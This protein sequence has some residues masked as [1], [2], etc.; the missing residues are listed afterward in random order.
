MNNPMLGVSAEDPGKFVI[1]T[2][3]V[4]EDGSAYFKVPSGVPIFFQALDATGL[5]TL[6][7]ALPGQTLS[8]VGCHEHR[9]TAPPLGAVLLAAS[10]APSRIK[11]GPQGSWPLRFDQL[12]QPVLDRHCVECHQPG[13]EGFEKAAI[14][15]T[16]E[17]AWGS[18]VGFADGDLKKKAFERDISVPNEGVAANSRLWDMLAPSTGKSHQ[19]VLLDAANLARLATWMDT[20]AHWQ[21][22]F[23]EEQETE[24]MKFRTSVASVMTDDE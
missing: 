10:G 18:L 6:T 7:Y 14:D 4:H 23:S 9:E 16:P 22:S 8:C 19:G 1:G 11:P 20:Y 15:L 2:V 3:P 13:A 21:G 12:V 5:R 17:K 24:L